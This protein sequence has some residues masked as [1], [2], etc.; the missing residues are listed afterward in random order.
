MTD[1]ITPLMETETSDVNMSNMHG[2]NE[3]AAL[4][5]SLVRS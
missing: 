4:K 5:T 1:E 3:M 2:N